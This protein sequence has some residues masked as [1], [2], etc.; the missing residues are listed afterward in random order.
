MQKSFIFE[1]EPRIHVYIF[2]TL[3]SMT[4]ETWEILWASISLFGNGAYQFQI[5]C[6]NLNK[7]ICGKAFC[8]INGIAKCNDFLLYIS[9]FLFYDFRI[10]FWT[11]DISMCENLCVCVC[12]CVFIFETERD[13]AW[14]GEEKREGDVE[15]GAGSR[16]WAVSTEPDAGLELTNS[17]DHDL[18]QSQTH[19]LSHWGI[20]TRPSY[21]ILIR[22]II[23]P[24]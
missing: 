6:K 21:S 4:L 7:A 14:A 10:L 19:N 5:C 18:S 13:R 9:E 22:H 3:D 24:S 11:I 23:I 15:S 8:E 2:L 17:Q 20:P 1:C 12:V 16:L